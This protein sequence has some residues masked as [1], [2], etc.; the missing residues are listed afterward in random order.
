MYVCVHT[1]LVSGNAR[2]IDEHG[3]SDSQLNNPTFRIRA[4]NGSD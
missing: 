2:K 4:N 3:D 1:H